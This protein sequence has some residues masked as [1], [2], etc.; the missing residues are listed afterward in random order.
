MTPDLICY[1]QMPVW[2]A[3]TVPAAFLATTPR[4]AHG[5]NCASS[6]AV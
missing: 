2:H 4:K 1:K 3:D 6:Q 5:A